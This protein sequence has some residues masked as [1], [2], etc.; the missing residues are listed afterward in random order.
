[1]AEVSKN[2]RDKLISEDEIVTLLNKGARSSN[3][4]NA[5]KYLEKIIEYKGLGTGIGDNIVIS[6][7]GIEYSEYF[8]DEKELHDSREELEAFLYGTE[9]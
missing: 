2:F 5:L 8:V 1:M 7:P 3:E 4:Q 6:V 9:E